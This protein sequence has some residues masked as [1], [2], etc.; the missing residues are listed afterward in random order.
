MLAFAQRKLP[1]APRS[2]SREPAGAV[3]MRDVQ[4]KPV[5]ADLQH[6]LYPRSVISVTDDIRPSGET[7]AWSRVLQG[8][9][10]PPAPRAQRVSSLGSGAGLLHRVP[11]GSFDHDIAGS[12]PPRPSCE[13]T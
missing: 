7:H 9:A 13:A 10:R 8:V 2:C 12:V 1:F 5:V 4:L 6:R 3:E 11:F